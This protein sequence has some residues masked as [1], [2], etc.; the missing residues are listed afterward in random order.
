MRTDPLR[1]M[2][3]D[4]DPA[5][6]GQLTRDLTQRSIEVDAFADSREALRHLEVGRH[7]AV[8]CD[9]MLPGGLCGHEFLLAAQTVDNSVVTVLLT[10]HDPPP[11]IEPALHRL[12]ATLARPVTLDQLLHVLHTARQ[13]RAA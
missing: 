10:W 5:T 6:R 2:I 11:G 9:Q 12:D 8:I 1:V 3:V 7:D 13:R 4:D